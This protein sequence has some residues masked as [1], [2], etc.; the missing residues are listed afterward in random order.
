ML[1]HVEF[2]SDRFPPREGEQEKVNPGL[3]G[4]RLAEFLRDRL[5][6]GG[7]GKVTVEQTAN[8]SRGNL[9]PSVLNFRLTGT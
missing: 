1:T 4:Q 8:A 3:W 7:H 6:D 9:Q 2:R 5:R